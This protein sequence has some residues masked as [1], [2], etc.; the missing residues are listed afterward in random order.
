MTAPTTAP[1]S[2]MQRFL[3]SVDRY[4]DRPAL[5]ARGEIRTYAELGRSV[6]G[7]LRLIRSRGLAR[8]E[9]IGI[10]TGDDCQTYAAI[11]AILA[12]G[13][14]YVPLNRKSPVARNLAVIDEA[15][16]D[17]IL[18]S[19]PDQLTDALESSGDGSIATIGVHAATAGD[20]E[21]P[22]AEL[23]SEMSLAYVF[24]TSGSTG[25][26]KGVPISHSNLNQFMSVMLD[27]G[28]Y[29]FG[30]DDR[31]LQMF[32]LTFDLSV[33]SFF[34]PLSV[35]ACCCVVPESRVGY[36]TTLKVL[37]DER[38]TVALMVPSLLVYL[39][40]FLAGLS[41]P[42]LRM[43]LF[44]GEALPESVTEKWQTAA[45]DS[46]I[47]NVYGPTEATI[48]CLRYPWSAE[49]S[50]AAAVNGLVPIG[51]PFPGMDLALLDADGDLVTARGEKGELLLMGEQVTSG[52]WRNPA[53]TAEAFV[54]IDRAGQ[55]RRA[56]RTGDLCLVDERGDYVY[57]GRL[58][59]QV[60][61]DGHRVELGEIEHHLRELLGRSGL[62][63]VNVADGLRQ[64]LAVFIEQPHID[65]SELAGRLKERVP[66]YML[67][68]HVR[69]VERLPLNLNGKVDRPVLRKM[70]GA[71]AP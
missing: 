51:A 22:S 43:S 26:P 59:G 24:F 20:D 36:V 41:L 33:M 25:K 2:V 65:W 69:V 54:Q 37:R 49:A 10:V 12:N 29:D 48:F 45:P 60:K 14:A 32:E 52:Y 50:P 67:P 34:V 21:I 70:F 27:S 5:V 8:A 13:S 57:C 47:E 68:K 17:A 61:I 7:I 64:E 46:L 71:D 56:Y 16:P 31:F 6:A 38:V 19:E 39:E 1:L 62:A 44:C 30:P 28:M 40:Q 42:E 11:L 23:A 63:V 9:R 58:D 66:E 3:T 35:G 18:Y 55:S 15:C 4:P 53:R